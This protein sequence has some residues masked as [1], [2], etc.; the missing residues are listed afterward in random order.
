MNDSAEDGQLE[1][2]KRPATRSVV[3]V[4]IFCFLLLRPFH[5]AIRTSISPT[6]L[7]DRELPTYLWVTFKNNSQSWIESAVWDKR[8]KRGSG[9]LTHLRDSTV[10]PPFPFEP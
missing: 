6:A 10:W 9:L 8:R 2:L 1:A 4:I 3:L 7:R 5:H